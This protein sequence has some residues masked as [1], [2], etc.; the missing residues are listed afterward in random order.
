MF[1]AIPLESTPMQD[2]MMSST[3]NLESA[4]KLSFKLFLSFGLT[5]S[6]LQRGSHQDQISSGVHH[7]FQHL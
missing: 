5:T 3:D 4:S 6:R 1:D 7:S 2:V